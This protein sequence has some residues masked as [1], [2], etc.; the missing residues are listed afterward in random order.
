[1]MAMALACGLAHSFQAE[2]R[3]GVAGNG[4]VHGFGIL[5]SDGVINA[6]GIQGSG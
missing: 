3:H 5:A 6:D 2:A 4:V 1:M